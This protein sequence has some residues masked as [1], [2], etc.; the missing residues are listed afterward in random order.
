MFGELLER[1]LMIQTVIKDMMQE[2]VQLRNLEYELQIH[3]LNRQIESLSEQKDQFKKICGGIKGVSSFYL[4]QSRTSINETVCSDDLSNRN[5]EE[6]KSSEFIKCND[7]SH[8]SLLS[9]LEELLVCPISLERLRNPVMLPSGETIDE[10]TLDR[11]SENDNCDPYTRQ[12]LLDCK[13]VNKLAAML[14]EIV[15]KNKKSYAG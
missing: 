6:S 3:D 12:S 5:E 11:F 15:E 10:S 2:R 9:D 13:V 1:D 4:K 14:V 7:K 8:K